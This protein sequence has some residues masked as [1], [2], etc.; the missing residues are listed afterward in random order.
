MTI[1]TAAENIAKVQGELATI[2]RIEAGFAALAK[3]HPADVAIDVTTAKGMKEAVSARAA[4]RDP[5]I[6][7]EKARKAAKAPVLELGRA[8]DA[9]AATLT[10]RLLE[11]EANYDDQ[12][13]AEEARKEAE[14][15]A[16]VR[17]EVER[18][19]DLQVRVGELRG[20]IFVCN[21]PRTTAEE[22]QQHIVDLV[23]VPVDATFQEFQQQAEE[24][25]ASTL[26]TL[27]QMHADAVAREA[28]AARI[29]AWVAFRSIRY[30][31][32]KASCFGVTAHLPSQCR[33][34]T[35]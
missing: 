11:G 17:Q 12:I 18:V 27:R 6:A 35:A 34:A 33:T 4:W 2:D 20:A 32:T 30:S 9:R 13:K 31:R 3:A 16:K 7:V 5:R 26:T 25:K 8:I 21:L 19:S 15:E 28:E 23:A 22:I 29:A 1:D 24:A 14:R 10:T